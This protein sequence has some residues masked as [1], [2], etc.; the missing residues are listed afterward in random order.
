MR[1]VAESQGKAGTMENIFNRDFFKKDSFEVLYVAGQPVGIGFEIL[2]PD[3]RG[4]HLSCI[5]D[6]EVRVND[7]KVDSACVRFCLGG[8]VFPADSLPYL[9]DEYWDL[10][11]WAQIQILMEEGQIPGA[12]L[13]ED[14][15]PGMDGEKGC[16]LRYR[17]K[18]PQKCMI[19]VSYKYRVPFT[20]TRRE[21]VRE[22]VKGSMVCVCE[23]LRKKRV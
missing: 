6:F 17:T 19:S 9:A 23:K 7:E 22:C 8:K 13:E 16:A 10:R 14:G 2:F 1:A 4:T 21:C 5:E 15:M 18:C 11:T 20:G 12:E 3:S